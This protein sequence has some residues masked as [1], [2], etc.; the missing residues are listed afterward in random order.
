MSISD[1][2]SGP[3]ADDKSSSFPI[4]LPWSHD[5]AGEPGFL[6]LLVSMTVYTLL[7]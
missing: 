5:K 2:V 4:A 1:T 3:D 7:Y 6:T